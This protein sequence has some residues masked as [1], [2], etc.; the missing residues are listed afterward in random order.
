MLAPYPVA[1]IELSA[2]RAHELM[3]L[4]AALD[5]LDLSRYSYVSIHAPS[6]FSPQDEEG[7]FQ[8]LYKIRHRGWPVIVHPDTLY[9]FSLWRLL[10]D[11]L[12]V[13]NMDKRKPIGRTVR[14]LEYLFSELPQASFCFDIGHARQVD[15][16]M[17]EAYR[18]LKSFSSRLRQVHI[19]EVNTL[20]K[21]DRLSFVSIRG[22]QEVAH[23]I[24][25]STP[26]IIESVVA[27]D[28]I[29]AEICRVQSAL[30]APVEQP[31]ATVEAS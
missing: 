24:P 9:D 12:C 23:L 28:Q 29:S 4:L 31:R 27:E 19:S 14:E 26:V 7:I 30:Q 22:F 16:S 20:N 8:E 5:D 15:T 2:I 1:A 11:L 21:H 25:P 13:E 17:T 3:P 6:E 18:M 10:G